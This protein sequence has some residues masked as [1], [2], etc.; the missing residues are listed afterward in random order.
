MCGKGFNSAR[1]MRG[2]MS[3]KH[4]MQKDFKC[5]QCHREFGYKRSL[6]EHLAIEHQ[7]VFKLGRKQFNDI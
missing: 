2:H 4:N 5:P 7:T 6:K 1:D 3:S